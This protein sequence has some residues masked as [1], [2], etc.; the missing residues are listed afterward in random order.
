MHKHM[1]KTYEM[2]AANKINIIK[3][4]EFMKC[5]FKGQRKY[6]LKMNVNIELARY[7]TIDR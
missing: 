5:G 3:N 4:N 7:I 1:Y 6:G 2:H